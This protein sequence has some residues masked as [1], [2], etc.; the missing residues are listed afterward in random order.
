MHTR[1]AAQ[2]ATTDERA[3]KPAWMLA[4][5]G[6]GVSQQRAVELQSPPPAPEANGAAEPQVLQTLRAR[7]NA[8]S[9]FTHDA[10]R[11]CIGLAQRSRKRCALTRILSSML[12]CLQ[13]RSLQAA[14]VYHATMLSPP[15][16]S[17]A[18][19]CQCCQCCHAPLPFLLQPEAE[20]E[21]EPQ[22]EPEPE[23]AAPEI[24]LIGIDDDGGSL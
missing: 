4:G 11:W 16:K 22:P 23:P 24:P 9:P 18:Q 6:G 5:D 2:G 17:G 19:C 21:P 7:R 8:D 20:P 13:R 3:G 14:S 15:V 10:A 1:R 12:P